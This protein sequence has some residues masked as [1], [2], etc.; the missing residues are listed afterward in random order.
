MLDR[1]V[2]EQLEQDVRD[3]ECSAPQLT[4]LECILLGMYRKMSEA[5][6]SHLRRLA[7]M[8]ADTE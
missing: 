8:M 4:Q 3:R 2:L 1:G 7:E 6:K 5:D